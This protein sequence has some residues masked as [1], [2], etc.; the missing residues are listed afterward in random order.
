M[1]VAVTFDTLKFVK[2]LKDAGVPEAHAE[3]FSSAV[4][5]SHETAE[6][7]TKADLREYDSAI[8]HE[9]TDVRHEIADLRKDMNTLGAD[10]RKEIHT[11]GTD[12]RKDMDTLGADL[13]KDMHNLGA[14]LRKDM[15]VLG[16]SIII[17]LGSLL[18]VAV[19]VLATVL[20]LL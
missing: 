6:L 8:R 15:L 9:I 3:A 13:R 4:R 2:T 18:V 17:K 11:L 20:K 12:L 19:G 5:D 1:M 10:L 7:V 16:Q 14:D